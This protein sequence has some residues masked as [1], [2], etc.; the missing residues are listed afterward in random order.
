MP[1]SACLLRL[2]HPRPRVAHD[3]LERPSRLRES[4]F[5]VAISQ[6]ASC[7]GEHETYESINVLS[8]PTRVTVLRALPHRG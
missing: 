4:T 2:H 7:P 1:S 3:G 8:R 5:G 6:C